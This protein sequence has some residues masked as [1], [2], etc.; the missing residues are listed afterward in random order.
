VGDSGALFCRLKYTYSADVR[1]GLVTIGHGNDVH[2]LP[3]SETVIVLEG[4]YTDYRLYAV[5]ERLGQELTEL[6]AGDAVP[7]REIARSAAVDDS[8]I[9]Y[10]EPIGGEPVVD[11]LVYPETNYGPF[12]MIAYGDALRMETDY[13]RELDYGMPCAKIGPER[14]NAYLKSLE[15][16][17]VQRTESGKVFKLP[18]NAFA[19]KKESLAN[20]VLKRVPRSNEYV[21]ID[22]K[23]AESDDEAM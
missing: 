2:F 6:L 7:L 18:Q 5:S 15:A 11:A 10:D 1:N 16:F 21:S 22:D 17:L 4:S 3:R 13:K 19:R 14:Y 9:V 20:A 12:E 23:D 8:R